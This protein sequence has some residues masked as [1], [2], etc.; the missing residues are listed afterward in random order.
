M[1]FPYLKDT[2][3]R[4]IRKAGLKN[5]TGTRIKR[6]IKTAQRRE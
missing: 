5:S 3:P 2:G 4:R 6:K 1:E